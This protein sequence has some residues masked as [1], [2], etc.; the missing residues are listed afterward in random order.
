ME[1][2][3]VNLVAGWLGMLCGIVSGAGA[4]LFFYRD[5]WLGGYDSWRRRLVRLGHISFFG[6]AFVNV[7]FAFSAPPLRLSG[8]TLTL[9]SYAL[10]VAAVTMPLCCYLSA[11]RQPLRHLFPIPVVAAATGILVALIGCWRGLKP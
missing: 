11:W 8:L 2:I 5:E 3:T 1:T 7:L 10:I 4:G 6:L 9:G